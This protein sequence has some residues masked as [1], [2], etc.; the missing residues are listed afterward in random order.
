[1]IIAM[2][3]SSLALLAAT[4]GLILMIRERK[5]SQKRNTALV[6]YVERMASDT[7]VKAKAEAERRAAEAVGTIQTEYDRR[8]R[9]LENGVV[10]DFEKAKEAAKAVNDFN[11]SIANIMGFD[12][13]ESLKQQRDGNAGGDKG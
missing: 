12:P 2:I 1:M 7:L 10:P 5:R 3:M 13:F 9:D 6:R 8:I 4:A 11:D